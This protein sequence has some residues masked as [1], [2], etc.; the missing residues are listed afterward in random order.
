MEGTRT[1]SSSSDF[2]SHLKP[3]LLPNLLTVWELRFSRDAIDERR[4]T[5][6]RTVG[7]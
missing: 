6:L 7:K 3:T 1:K 5:T 2:S 4:D